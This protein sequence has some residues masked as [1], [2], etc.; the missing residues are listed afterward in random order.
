MKKNHAL[1]TGCCLLLAAFL[2]GC[3]GGP[4]LPGST[5]S[6]ATGV[7]LDAS[8]VP[9]YLG[10][11]TSSVDVVMQTC[12]AGPPPVDEKFTDHAA[13]L[14]VLARLINSNPQIPPGTLYIEKYT[15]QYTPSQDSLGA[16]PIETDTRYDTIIIT[17]PPS[18]TGT[19]TTTATVV[20]VD[21]N[22]KIKYYNDISSGA[23]TSG[24]AY[25][26]NYTATYTFDGQNEY[27]EKFS[28]VV[29][30]SFQIGSFNNC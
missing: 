15:I 17:P 28:F 26:N 6:R 14:T 10:T 16:P 25:I 3:G 1:F 20:F 23:Y 13:T 2:W 19:T 29:Q 8:L 9:S 4:G 30:A 5:G 22:R 21:L 24:T 7:I 11:S 12:S 27:G 18:G